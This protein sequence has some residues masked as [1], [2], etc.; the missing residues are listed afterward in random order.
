MKVFGRGAFGRR[1]E[2]GVQ[3]REKGD[4]R[5]KI[6]HNIHRYDAVNLNFLGH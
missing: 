4:Q 6:Q 1:Q 2:R 3:K 5:R